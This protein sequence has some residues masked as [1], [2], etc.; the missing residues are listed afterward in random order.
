MTRSFEDLEVG[1]TH[2]FGTYDVTEAEILEFAEKYDP[3]PFHTD[4]EA[5]AE[6]M[7]GGLIA[8]GWHTAA[9]LMRMFVDGF[10]SETAALGSP[11]IDELRWRAPVRPGDTLSA[12]IEVVDVEASTPDRGTA[13]I[14]MAAVDDD[15]DPV[16]TMRGRIMFERRDGP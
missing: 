7:Y 4:P 3:Q 11:G 1:E 8:S 5:A 10:L 13:D 16:L 12:R 15:G 2:E 14:D 6:S 9:M